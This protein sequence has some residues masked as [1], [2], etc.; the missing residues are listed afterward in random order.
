MEFALILPVVMILMFG[1]FEMGYYFWN[2]HIVVQSVREGSRFAA[3]LPFSKFDCSSSD[4]VID[5]NDPSAPTAV[6]TS[7]I[8]KIKLI[9]R[10]GQ[11]ASDDAPPR[12][13]NWTANVSVVVSCPETAVSEGLYDN[14]A[15]AP[16]VTVS[17]SNVPY[18]SLF[19]TLGFDAVNVTLNASSR[20]PVM[21][22]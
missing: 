6:D 12:I 2:Q 17:A 13:K 4:I 19:S 1:S 22:L 14:M 5:R 21:G 15:N 3:R 20:S 8:D 9:T 16:I 11:I 10:T 18:P 7:T